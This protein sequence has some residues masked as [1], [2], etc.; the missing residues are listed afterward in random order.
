[1]QVQR[2]FVASVVAALGADDVCLAASS[3]ANGLRAAGYIDAILEGYY[4]GTRADE[5][6]ARPGTWYRG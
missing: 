2:P 3:A 5:F 4:G 1:M 6:W